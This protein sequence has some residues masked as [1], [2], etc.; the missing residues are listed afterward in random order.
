MAIGNGI[1]VGWG[2]TA[3]D[4]SGV[5]EVSGLLYNLNNRATYFENGYTTYLLLVDLQTC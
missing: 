1:G 3:I 4:D 2:P 5:Y